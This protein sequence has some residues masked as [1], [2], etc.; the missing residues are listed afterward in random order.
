MFLQADLEISLFGFLQNPI[1]C[2]AFHNFSGAFISYADR[3]MGDNGTH[4]KTF[5]KILCIEGFKNPW[6]AATVALY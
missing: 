3:L 4:D 6:N 5:T 2:Y 1:L